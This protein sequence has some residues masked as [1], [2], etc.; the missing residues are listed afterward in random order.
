MMP[1]VMVILDGE[2]QRGSST[3]IAFLVSGL[4][5]SLIG[6]VFQRIFRPGPLNLVQSM[7]VCVLGWI[8]FSLLGALPFVFILRTSLLN[9]FFEAMSGFTTTG[10]TMFTGLDVMPKSIIL[11]RSLTQWIGGLGIL[12]FFL[13]IT[14]RGG[15]A[16]MLFGAESHKIGMERP[17]PGLANTLKIL[18]SIYTGFTI[19]ITAALCT[20]GMS[21]FDS[22]CHSFTALS[23]GGFSP[24]DASISYYVLAGYVHFR[25]IEYIL[26]IG[27]LLGGTNF[28]IHYRVISRDWKALFDTQEMRFWWLLLMVFFGLIFFERIIRIEPLLWQPWS[29]GFWFAIEEHV[30]GV[31]FQVVAIITTTGFATQDIGGV[32]FGHLARQ[33][34][35]IMMVIGG[36][37][38][39]TGGGLKV[40][41]IGILI[42]VIKREVLR[43][44]RPRQALSRV[45]IDGNIVDTDEILRV[46]GLFFAWVLLLIVGGGVTALLSDLGAYE[47]FSGMFSALGNIGPCYISVDMLGQLHPLIKL[48]YIVGMLAGRLEILPVLL[49]FSR[50]TWQ[51]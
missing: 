44:L 13:A 48:V 18:W 10:I 26:I 12:T 49:L 40:L 46:S 35:L 47:S 16:H 23:T 24:H 20:T 9:G 39:S 45:I 27:M 25:W 8:L 33:L 30:R 50:Q 37:V 42:Q 31:L 28:L 22:I 3:L 21:L 36:C 11:W 51:S 41:R 43:I 29:P 32:Y 6:I 7:L 14:Y 34:F 4:I 1:I 38:G 19:V 5:T 17:V 15:G 2:L